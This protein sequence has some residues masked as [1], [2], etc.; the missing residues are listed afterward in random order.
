MPTQ[1]CASHSSLL[2][3]VLSLIMKLNS[4]LS[5]SVQIPGIKFRLDDRSCVVA[6]TRYLE[7]SGATEKK[8][9]GLQ[10]GC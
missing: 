1:Y 10:R 6:P 2:S 3:A 9:I 8:A 5:L 4:S 7:K